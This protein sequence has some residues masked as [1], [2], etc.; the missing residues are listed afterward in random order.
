MTGTGTLPEAPPARS[1]RIHSNCHSTWA[2][3]ETL[4]TVNPPAGVTAARHWHYDQKRENVNHHATVVT[5]QPDDGEPDDQVVDCTWAQWRGLTWSFTAYDDLEPFPLVRPV[6]ECGRK[7]HAEV[8]ANIAT[9][10]EPVPEWEFGSDLTTIRA[11]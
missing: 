9:E 3:F 6:E 2:A 4:A 1:G 10:P 7:F 11:S 8:R 5:Y